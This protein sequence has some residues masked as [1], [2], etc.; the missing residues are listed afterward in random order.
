MGVA[1]EEWICVECGH[2]TYWKG[3]SRWPASGDATWP[4]TLWCAYQHKN[5][6]HW[7]S[8]NVS[9]EMLRDLRPDISWAC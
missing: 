4:V 8:E 1:S 3:S 7:R 9:R 5:T 6:S 2:C